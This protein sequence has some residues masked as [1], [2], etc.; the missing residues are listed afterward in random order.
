M[1]S[2]RTFSLIRLSTHR[3]KLTPG[4]EGTDSSWKLLI[5]GIPTLKDS[6]RRWPFILIFDAMTGSTRVR[7]LIYLCRIQTIHLT[8]YTAAALFQVFRSLPGFRF[9]QSA[10]AWWS[11][12]H[13]TFALIHYHYD[14]LK[15]IMKSFAHSEG[16]TKRRR[17]SCPILSIPSSIW[18]LTPFT[19]VWRLSCHHQSRSPDANAL[20]RVTAS[21]VLHS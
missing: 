2:S 17:W 7:K 1:L 12:L 8:Y 16:K 10:L 14:A 3:R 20:L 11:D 9:I 18:Y 5:Q 21:R 6:I 13:S 19:K 15:K 4:P